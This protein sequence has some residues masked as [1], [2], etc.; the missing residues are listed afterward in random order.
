MRTAPLLGALAA[1]LLAHAAS[2]GIVHFANPAPG[3]PGHYDWRWER[4]V[5]WESW[6]DITSSSAEQSGLASGSSVGQL[7]TGDPG[8][9]NRTSGG[10]AVERVFM[11]SFGLFITNAHAAGSV[12]GWN[13]GLFASTLAVHAFETEPGS[14]V[15]AFTEGE[16]LYIGARTAGGN[17]GWIEVERTGMTFA[18]FAWAYETEPGVP[19]TAGQVPAPGQAFVFAVCALGACTRRRST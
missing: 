16:R 11:N 12:I 17:Y 1:G 19:I 7:A 4:V 6:L 13:G 15:T 8:T 9:V 3:R 18:A 5:G 2:A 14:E 10:A